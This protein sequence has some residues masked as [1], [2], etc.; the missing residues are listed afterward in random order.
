VVTGNDNQIKMPGSDYRNH[1][2]SISNSNLTIDAGLIAKGK[3]GV[4]QSTLQVKGKTQID[5][6]N[7]KDFAGLDVLR[8][9]KAT[10][11]KDVEIMQKG[12]LNIDKGSEVSIK[13]NLD[14]KTNADVRNKGTLTVEGDTTLT[15][16][17]NGG[18]VNIETEN[19]ATT[20]F[21]KNVT[22]NLAELSNN[23]NSKV[24]IKGNLTLTDSDV[25]LGDGTQVNVTGNL[26]NKSTGKT[27]EAGEKPSINFDTT[28]SL[29]VGGNFT[30]EGA[31]AY[32]TDSSGKFA[33]I[34]VQGTTK[35]KDTTWLALYQDEHKA[36]SGD[37]YDFTQGVS[38]TELIES[39]GGIDQAIDE[40]KID[41]YYADKN[42]PKADKNGLVK[43]DK[44]FI[45]AKTYLSDDKTKLLVK[46]GLSK[47]AEDKPVNEKIASVAE[48][49][50]KAGV[51]IGQRELDIIASLFGLGDTSGKGNSEATVETF[52]LAN[53]ASTGDASAANVIKQTAVGIEK[54]SELVASTANDTINTF[55]SAT[56]SEVGKRVATIST[57]TPSSKLASFINS[58]NGQKF[59]DNGDTT[60][61]AMMADEMAE[62]VNSFY[63]NALAAKGKFKNGT[64]PKIYGG[65]F[66]YDRRIDDVLVG[67]YF[68]YTNSKTKVMQIKS[69]V[70]ELGIYSKYY[71]GE[72]EIGFSLASGYGKNK[73][74]YA[75]NIL[76]KNVALDAKFNSKYFD[77]QA[78]YGYRFA[79][80]D[81]ASIKPYVA[82][83][84]LG[85]TTD[86]Y[87][88]KTARGAN[89]QDFGKNTSKN[90]K[91]KIGAESVAN[92]DKFS[93]Y[94]DAKIKRDLSKDD[95]ETRI[96]FAGSKNG[97]VT[98]G[99]NK[100]HTN[101]ALDL[102]SSVNL[103]KHFSANINF[104]VDANNDDKIYS[105]SLGLAYKF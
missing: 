3:I 53:K 91:A 23:E 19:G 21:N 40:S 54:N 101:F 37:S 69:N 104:G 70:Y 55:S 57:R 41:V 95:G 100:K 30:N 27:F 4:S 92:F 35:L 75:Q 105:T 42:N 31:L 96:N 102:G 43:Y 61:R 73:L 36:A 80:N 7:K 58:L 8:N 33:K 38:G 24:T 68:S 62:Y 10:F 72:N 81:K 89:F 52:K 94:A 49:A 64:D 18:S 39:K 78:D 44:N 46:I 74:N 20:T 99:E 17:Q 98:K 84:Y 12:N 65:I 83:E 59:A 22:L 26:T 47:L 71:L 88:T 1:D 66:G 97:F 48:A 9:S 82:L 103:S 63:F 93:L 79:L 67:G 34:S 6:M 76:G 11:E 51:N 32:G 85:T 28:S 50:Q 29:K 45:G 2:V 60:L 5:G 15:G 25:Q 13:G 56:K 90:L 87:S 14:I 86:A 16:T 77:V